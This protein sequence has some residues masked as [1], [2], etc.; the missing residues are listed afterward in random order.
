MAIT[1]TP[2]SGVAGVTPAEFQPVRTPKSR[3]G[4]RS[5]ATTARRLES[6]KERRREG[7]RLK[8]RL[9]ASRTVGDRRPSTSKGQAAA[10]TFAGPKTANRTEQKCVD[11]EMKIG[12]WNVEGLATS[13]KL[14]MVTWQM[15]RHGLDVLAIQETHLRGTKRFRTENGRMDVILSGATDQSY[16]NNSGQRYAAGVGLI[17]SDRAR[18]ALIGYEAVS[19]RVLTAQFRL[20]SR[21]LTIICAYITQSMLPVEVRRETWD[22]VDAELEKMRGGQVL[23]LGDMNARLR[24]RQP[25]EE[26]VIGRHMLQ[27]RDWRVGEDDDGDLNRA[28]LIQTLRSHDLFL[29]NTAFQHRLSHTVTYRDLSVRDPLAPIHPLHCRFDVLDHVATPTKWLRGV[30]DIRVY[31]GADLAS[32]HYLGVVTLRTAYLCK[33]KK[34]VRKRWPV[35]KL[36]DE[37]GKS[38]ERRR[39]FALELADRNITHQASTLDQEWNTLKEC[40]STAADKVLGKPTLTPSK[41]WISDSTMR[42]IEARQEA[43]L[44]R[45]VEE[46][47][48]LDKEIKREVR[49]DKREFCKK[50]AMEGWKGAKRLRLGFCTQPA[51]LGGPSEKNAEAHAAFLVKLW[52]AEPVQ[53]PERAPLHD[54]VADIE[55]GPITLEEVEAALIGQKR[56]RASGIDAIPMELWQALNEHPEAMLQL[57]SIIARCWEEK[58]IP[59]EWS[60][61]SVVC[62]HKKGPTSEVANYRPISL[63]STAYKVYATILQQRLVSGLEGRLWSTQYGF[64]KGH[65][66]THAIALLR[67]IMEGTLLTKDTELHIAFLD[68]R[69]AFDKVNRRGLLSAMRRIGVP[70]E[71]CKAVEGIYQDVRFVV[72]DCGA[73][74]AQHSS[75]SGIRQGCPLSPYLFIILTT[76][77]MADSVGSSDVLPCHDI[78]FADDTN[79]IS[80]SVQDL[81]RLLHSV[82]SRAAEDGLEVAASKCGHM[83]V[84]GSRGPGQRL[85]T[86]NG[87]L[88]PVITSQVHLG[89]LVT[90]D[91]RSG[92]ELGRR[93]ST[94]GATMKKLQDFWK[95]ATTAWK[96]RVFNAV[97]TSQVLYGLD[98]TWLLKG[99]L[100]RLDAAQARWLRRIMHIP[101]AYYSRITDETVRERSQQ[102]RWSSQL[103]QRQLVLYG[104]ILRLENSDPLRM[105]TFDD[106]LNQPSP[107]GSSKKRG[108]PRSFWV[109]EVGAIARDRVLRLPRG[110]RQR[111]SVQEVAQDRNLWR[112]ICMTN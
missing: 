59:S 111:R 37:D 24:S 57:H 63:L 32:H 55:T 34:P 10:K 91:Q 54:T 38:S 88:V 65:S 112:K 36:T 107:P 73:A 8:R 28:M 76:A 13:G 2:S 85:K 48:H 40:V 68:W 56:G 110:V 95:H 102:V 20:K 51:G 16:N 50:L 101:S 74:S 22:L 35:D 106:N 67:R 104:H 62:L 30:K 23:L 42:L 81:T 46:Q 17:L 27:T 71:M 21:K 96:L 33:I 83:R 47:L 93:L 29:A 5:P 79:L 45:R 64:R 69:K 41:P 61:A 18:K 92:K 66:T 77:V 105:A 94:A 109:K 78:A 86:W 49:K 72:N 108:R 4:Q 19:D 12:Y 80:Q 11:G 58:S 90:N 89:S 84:N 60:L 103:L 97:I 53:G 82:E 100:K 75:T 44:G 70:E 31:R 43:R 39:Q 87:E 1:S 99:D 26:D 98:T 52:S 15:K 3:R 6:F 9:R 14:K 25:G 7:R